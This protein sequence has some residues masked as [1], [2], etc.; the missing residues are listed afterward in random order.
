MTSGG[1][2]ILGDMVIVDPEKDS[3]DQ[4][5]SNESISAVTRQV[6]DIH[7]TVDNES[8]AAV[9]QQPGEYFEVKTFTVYRVLLLGRNGIERRS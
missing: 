8:A 4:P 6:E 7:V 1:V 2:S 3:S 5:D 9:E